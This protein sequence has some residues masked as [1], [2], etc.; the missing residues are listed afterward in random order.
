MNNNTINTTI[1]ILADEAVKM[2]PIHIEKSYDKIKLNECNKNEDLQEIEEL[3]IIASNRNTEFGLSLINQLNCFIQSGELRFTAQE[4]DT[5]L[6]GMSVILSSLMATY[7]HTPSSN[8]VCRRLVR[9][10]KEDLAIGNLFEVMKHAECYASSSKSVR[11]CLL[12]LTRGE[13]FRELEKCTYEISSAYDERVNVEKIPLF[14]QMIPNVLPI[15]TQKKLQNDVML[16]FSDPRRMAA[17]KLKKLA[18]AL[19][20]N[21]YN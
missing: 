18:F 12:K 10:N 19:I 4:W 17:Y 1:D 13:Q 14:T 11:A 7:I 9:E 15:V 21:N 2:N 20:H 16:I 8:I 6:K 3:Y 5:Y